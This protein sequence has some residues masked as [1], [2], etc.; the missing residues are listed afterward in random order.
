MDVSSRRHTTEAPFGAKADSNKNAIRDALTAHNDAV[1][2]L[3]N[4]DH[5]WRDD[6]WLSSAVRDM[7]ERRN[8]FET[9]SGCF[10]PECVSRLSSNEIEAAHKLQ[11]A[12]ERVSRLIA[13]YRQR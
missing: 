5:C 4:C 10:H 9:P 7:Q 6:I 12:S 1:N 11:A 13:L 2:A 3:D 8:A